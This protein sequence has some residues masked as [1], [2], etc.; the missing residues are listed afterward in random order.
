MELGESTLE[1]WALRGAWYFPEILNFPEIWDI[2]GPM[3]G[4]KTHPTSKISPQRCA[5]TSSRWSYLHKAWKHRRTCV[6]SS[7]QLFNKSTW[8]W[9]KREWKAAA[10]TSQLENEC[11]T[12]SKLCW[13]HKSPNWIRCTRA[14]S[15]FPMSS[16]RVDWTSRLCVPRRVLRPVLGDIWSL[17]TMWK[18]TMWMALARNRAEQ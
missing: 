15:I 16:G 4:M 10:N 14:I 5:N 12:N 18:S 8:R 9:T 7:R 1:K 17:S 2:F 6:D 13:M 11:S 3:N